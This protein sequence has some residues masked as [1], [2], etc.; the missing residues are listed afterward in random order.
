V[1]NNIDPKFQLRVQVRIPFIHDN[2]IDNELPW[3]SPLYGF[4]NVYGQFE[5]PRKN[6]LIYVF[7]HNG[8]ILDIAY[9]PLLYQ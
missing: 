1:V 8:D 3:A 6:S 4:S 5:V 7:M 9:I 2:L